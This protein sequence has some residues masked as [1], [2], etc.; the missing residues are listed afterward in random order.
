MRFDQRKPKLWRA[1]GVFMK[2][3]SV[4]QS[5]QIRESDKYLEMVGLKHDRPPLL[6]KRAATRGREFVALESL[7][8][9]NFMMT[10]SNVE[11]GGN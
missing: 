7:Q 11:L 8:K 1:D 9:I 3:L 5:E 4:I 2:P 10:I 6:P